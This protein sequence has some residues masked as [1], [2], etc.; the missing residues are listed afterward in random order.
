MN[1]GN[2][3]FTASKT[4]HRKTEKE[5]YVNRFYTCVFKR[6]HMINKYLSI[7]KHNSD[8]RHRHGI[9]NG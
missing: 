8:L 9:T 4:N 2:Y 1:R 3:I 7:N 5:K 6:T